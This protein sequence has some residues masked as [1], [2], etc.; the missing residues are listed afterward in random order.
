MPK[1]NIQH[2]TFNI[3]NY[4]SFSAL[5][6]AMSP[7]SPVLILTVSSTG[8]TKIR[9]SPTSPVCAAPWMAAMVGFHILITNHNIQKHTFDAAGIVHHTTINAS[10]AH[11]SLTSYIIIREPLDVGSQKCLLDILESRLADNCLNLLHN[12]LIIN[13]VLILLLIVSIE[14]GPSF[15][16][17]SNQVILYIMFVFGCKI[18]TFCQH[19]K[20]IKNI[21]FLLFH[22]YFKFIQSYR[23]LLTICK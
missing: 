5:Y 20:A 1:F 2:L 8:I 14:N 17:H 22:D 19:F 23:I 9:P 10:L 13:N 15:D 12:P 21:S 3:L 18:N 7:R 6:N 4:S 11:L 16:C